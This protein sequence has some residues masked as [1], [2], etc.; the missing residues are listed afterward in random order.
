[1]NPYQEYIQM[2]ERYLES[3]E[4][5]LSTDELES[6]I[7]LYQDLNDEIGRQQYLMDLY[8]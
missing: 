8:H 1:M 5:E 2:T 7:E 4:D 3:C 6:I